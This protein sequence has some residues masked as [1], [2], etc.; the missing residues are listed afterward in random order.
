M[1]EHGPASRILVAVG[2]AVGK[3]LSLYED[4]QRVESRDSPA[5]RQ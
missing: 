5:N 4:V 1:W 2:P 3:A